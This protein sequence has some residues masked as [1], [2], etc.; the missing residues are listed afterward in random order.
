VSESLKTA[1]NQLVKPPRER[2]AL[3]PSQPVSAI[4][5]GVGFA[6]PQSPAPSG[7]GTAVASPWIE[8]SRTNSDAVVDV[9]STDGFIVFKMPQTVDVTMQDA[10]RKRILLR[11]VNG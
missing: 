2:K 1:V 9:V 10:N 7:T 4:G 3:P 11:F 6:Q 5:A 8:Q